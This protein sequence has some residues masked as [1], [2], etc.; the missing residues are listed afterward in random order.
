MPS[1]AV[2]IRGI[3]LALSPGADR[4]CEKRNL[5]SEGLSARG[6]MAEA[7]EEDNTTMLDP[8]QVM[9]A[10]MT[11]GQEC[12]PANAPSVLG[13]VIGLRPPVVPIPLCF[14]RPG[15]LLCLAGCLLGACVRL[16]FQ[17]CAPSCPSLRQ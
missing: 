7:M 8:E 9:I 11:E 1:C 5:T 3:G 12:A 6:K 13:L 16:S 10:R 4:A 17:V 14:V 2:R 15:G